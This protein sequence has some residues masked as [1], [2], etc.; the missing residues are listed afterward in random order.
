MSV[1]SPLIS[2]HDA[3]VHFASESEGVRKA[4]NGFSLDIRP[5]EWIAVT[6]SNGS[7]KSTLAG[8]LLGSCPLSQGRV[9]PSGRVVVRGVMQH[10]D[11]QVLGDTIEEE[12]HFVLGA[13][14]LP[15]DEFERRQHEALRRV[16]LPL[17][18]S[19]PIGELSGGQKQLLNIALALAVRPDVL[20]LD[21]P[22]AM[23][24]P[25]A[26]GQVLEAVREAH[27]DGAAVVWIT[28]RLEEAAASERVIALNEG[29]L[30]FDGSPRLFLYGA[31]RPESLERQ[32]S[33]IP[34]APCERLALEPPFVV[35]TA[36][37]LLRRGV[38]L[39]ELPLHAD[40][41]AKAVVPPCR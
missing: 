36:A 34:A 9:I 18:A 37:A 38:P 41:L 30:A 33:A 1:F 35:R 7:G 26:R 40:D 32:P 29:A 20:V 19:T 28:H 24:D 27:R 8:I 22:T 31:E 14:G 3:S 12:F 39:R 6:G 4:L 13:I 21:E 11:A 17:P 2:I 23:L 16:R 10:P 25:D 15:A 5:G